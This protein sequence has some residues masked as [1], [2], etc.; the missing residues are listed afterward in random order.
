MTP[1]STPDPALLVAAGDAGQRFD[2]YLRKLL[3][4]LPLSALHR[5]LRQGAIRV[6]GRKAE[7]SLRLQEGAQ[8]TFRGP[9][10]G[11]ATAASAPEPVAQVPWSG[12]EPVILHR[13]DDVLAVAK[14]GGLPVQPGH[15][16]SLQDWL[17]SR[18][19]LWP[20]GAAR[21]FRPGPAHRLDR[22]TSGVVLCGLSAPG[23]RGLQ[24][25]FREGQVQK[26]Y[27]AV[28]RGAPRPPRATIDAPLRVLPD[29]RGDGPK[30]AVDAAGQPA[31]TH[32]EVLAARGGVAVLRVRIETGRTHQIRAHLAHLGHP[33][34]GD[35]RYGGG[36]GVFLLHAV[37]VRLPHP[38]TG[39][40]LDLT[41]PPPPELREFA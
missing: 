19:D 18:R 34:V 27:L 1:P 30:V 3:P 28:V 21:T 26:E 10:R 2:R 41:A 32:Y 31:V 17:L 14:P 4:A 5:L 7:A 12:P 16:P 25:A 39:V 15:G 24:A 38:V 36:G 33:L 37:R 8:V 11:L 9:A 20:A 23:L 22:S 40:E 6:D 35:R 29:A 13:D